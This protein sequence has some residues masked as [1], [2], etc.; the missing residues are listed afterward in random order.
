[1]L[2]PSREIPFENYIQSPIGLVPKDGGK[3]TRLIFHLSHPRDNT[4]GTSVNGSTPKELC[5]VKYKEFD[6]AVRI[7]INEGLA[8]YMGKSDMTSAFRHL[9]MNKKFWKYLVMKAQNPLDNQ[10][11]YFVDKCMPFGA[12]ISCSHFQRFSNAIAHIVSYYT[13]KENVNYLDDFLFA[14]L[15]ELLCNQQIDKFLEICENIRFPIS[16]EKTYWAT[17]K[18]SFLG[19]LIDTVNQLIC[20]PIEKINK[21]NMLINNILTKRNKKIYPAT[22]TTINWVPQF[23]WQS[24]NTWE[25]FH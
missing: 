9:A 13:H 16:M 24:C 3:K 7:C 25:S 17:T 18:L 14:H 20:V 15:M 10:W 2:A 19:L 23:S 4:K 5:S 11:Y 22:I 1:M 12:S 6:K 21:A 8:C